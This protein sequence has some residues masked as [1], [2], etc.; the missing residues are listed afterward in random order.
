MGL[1]P[2]SAEDVENIYTLSH[3]TPLALLQLCSNDLSSVTKFHLSQT[4]GI[5]AVFSFFAVAYPAS[6]PAERVASP[7]AIGTCTPV[8]A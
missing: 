6:V 8:P 5:L 2:L 3:A 4:G 7:K 1:F